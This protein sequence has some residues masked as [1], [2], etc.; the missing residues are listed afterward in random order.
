MSTLGT[1]A[2]MALAAKRTVAMEKRIL[3]E[4]MRIDGCQMKS[5]GRIA[6]DVRDRP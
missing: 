1:G 3:G 5:S 4:G 6:K 2:A